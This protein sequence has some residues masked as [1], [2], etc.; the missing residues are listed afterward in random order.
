AITMLALSRV[1]RLAGAPRRRW[2]GTWGT[3]RA[4]VIV[5]LPPGRGREGGGCRSGYRGRGEREGGGGGALG[6]ARPPSAGTRSPAPHGCRGSRGQSVPASPV[7]R[8]RAR[9]GRGC[10]RRCAV[11]APRR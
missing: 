9:P 4:V 1:E 6:L 5:R 2:R 8:G 10:R 3:R 11:P 7:R